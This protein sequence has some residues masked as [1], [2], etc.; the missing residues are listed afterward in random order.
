MNRSPYPTMRDRFDLRAYFVVGPDDTKGR[1]VAD[2]VATALRGGATFIQLRAKHADARDLTATAEAIAAVI[3]QAGKAD[4]VAFVIDDRVDAAWQCR[5][6]GIKVDG[7]H[8]GQDDMAPGQARALLGPDAIIGLSAET[9][10]HIKAANALSDGTIDYIGAGPL[11]Y[12]AT[13]PDAAAVEA[14]G[15]KHALGIAGA[16]LLCEAS[17]YPVVVGGGVH[18]DD[19]PALARTAAAGWFVVSAI[20]AAD[21]P[22]RATRELLQ[23]WTAVRGDARHGVAT[24]AASH[25]QSDV[26]AHPHCDTAMFNV[27]QPHGL[28]PVLTVAGSDSSGGAGIQADLKTMLANGVFGM[29]AITSLTAQNTTGV[30]A[31]Q[32]ADP[33]ILADQIDAVFEDIPPMAVK[34]GMVS[35]AALIETIADR[36]TAHQAR[37]IVLDPV[38]VATSGAKLIDDDAV[39]ALTTRLFPLTTVITPNMPETE[40]LLAQTMQER[41]SEDDT[42]STRLLSEGIRTEADMET[43]ARTLAEHFGCAV[44]VKGGHGIKDANDVLVE[45]DGTVTWFTSPRI[46]N[47]NTHGTGCT[48][49]SAIASHLAL[50]ETMPQAVRSAKEYLTGALAE[51]LDLGHGAG[52]MDHAWRWR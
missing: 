47:P 29:S 30:R 7:V 6:L 51:Q 23:A 1:P 9:L 19:V 39:A 14:D 26:A 2:V 49:S 17:R 32:N 41:T 11:H 25:P 37:N 22:E 15:T 8:I 33:A 12:T 28:P 34:I 36:L 5:E 3:A 44:L 45:P 38:M 52:P 21:D 40:A 10:P 48:L 35:S 31:V 50:G 24:S 46:D 18:A 20:A 4:T 43:A 27:K 16:Q 42:E 13:K